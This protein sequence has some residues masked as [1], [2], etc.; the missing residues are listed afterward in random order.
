MVRREETGHADGLSN[1]IVR[2]RSYPPF[3]C[4]MGSI[5]GIA[6]PDRKRSLFRRERDRPLESTALNM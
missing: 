2:T 4:H 3:G 1:T 6:L 5:K